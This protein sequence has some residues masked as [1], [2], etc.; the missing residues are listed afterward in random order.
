M[1]FEYLGRETVDAL[2]GTQFGVLSDSVLTA[3]SVRIRVE[4]L[5]DAGT[6]EP[7]AYCRGYLSDLD[8]P[9]YGLGLPSE[10]PEDLRLVI[11]YLP[12][13]IPMAAYGLR[14]FLDGADAGLVLE[15]PVFRVLPPAGSIQAD[16]LRALFPTP[17]YTTGPRAP[18]DLLRY[19]TRSWK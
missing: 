19:G 6:W 17:P 10:A 15:S 9:I 16:D 3:K 18:D 8:L 7:V 4:R 2:G 5:A 14:V 13:L 11:G 1:T 12:P